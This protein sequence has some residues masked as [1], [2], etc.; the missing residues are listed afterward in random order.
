M[1][2]MKFYKLDLA[3]HIKNT[4]FLSYQEEGLYM[5][6][7]HIHF[8]TGQPLPKDVNYLCSLVCKRKSTHDRKKVEDVLKKTFVE[9]ENGYVNLEYS[10]KFKS[11]KPKKEG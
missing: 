6:L 2:K 10:A 3:E 11:I 9:V 4:H 1:K 5:R 8:E 7:C